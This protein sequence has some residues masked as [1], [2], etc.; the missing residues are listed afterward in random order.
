MMRL[1]AVVLLAV[2]A[3]VPLSVGP[4]APPVAWLVTLAVA[5]GVIGV[6]AWSVPLVTAA[7]ALA[8]IAYALALAI[9]QPPP[10]LLGPLGL[11]ATLVLLLVLA[12]FASRTHGAAL[13]A[14]VIA[15]QARQAVAVTGV[16]AVAAVGLA[17]AATPLG[18]VLRSAPLPLVIVAAALGAAVTV[19]AGVALVTAVGPPRG[20][21]E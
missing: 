11:G 8:L 4:S 2:L 21:R 15:A 12:H 3:E 7:G 1:A 6:I 9:G 14:S 10:G 18:A 19:A 5:V 13:G 20:G 16:G 17:W